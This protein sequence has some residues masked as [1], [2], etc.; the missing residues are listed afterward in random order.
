MNAGFEIVLSGGVDAARAA[1]RAIAENHPALPQPAQYDL[2]LLVTELVTNAVRHGGA[3]EDRPL[4]LECQTRQGR[5]RVEVVD[6]GTDFDSP[7]RPGNGTG[8]GGWGLF[9]LDRIAES[10]GVCPAPAGTCVWF[11]VPAGATA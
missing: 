9:L 5:I 6:P 8:N 7:A 2:E 11:E 10:W 3:A 1:R 4:K